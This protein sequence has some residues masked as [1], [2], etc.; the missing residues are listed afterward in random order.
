MGRISPKEAKSRRKTSM[1]SSTMTSMRTT[2]SRALSLALA[3]VLTGLAVP[4]PR[5]GAPGD[6]CPGRATARST[7]CG[8]RS[9]DLPH[10]HQHRPRRRHRHRQ[11]GQSR[12]RSQARRFRDPGR[13]QAA[14]G[15]DVPAGQDR[16]HDAAGLHA[17]RA[18]H[19]QR[20][21]DR[22]RRREL[23]HLRVLPRR[24]SRHAR[25]QHVDAEAGHRLHR[26]PAGA[27]RS[28]HA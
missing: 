8:A 14:E 25:Q 26:Q 13:R 11:A 5:A 27:E 6:A 7:A 28:R 21:R 16:H 18:A 1:L 20:R 9:T 23:A 15:R 24:L 22:R 17:A 19:A 10:R 2:A 12:H 4:V 3:L